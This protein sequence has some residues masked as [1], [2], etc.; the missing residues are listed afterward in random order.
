[1]NVAILLDL[2]LRSPYMNLRFGRTN[3]LHLQGL[4]PT[5]QETS[6]QQLVSHAEDGGNTFF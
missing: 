1:M 5:E 6:A 3:H 2:A 4:K